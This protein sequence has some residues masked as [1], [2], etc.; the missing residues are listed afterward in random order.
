MER[1]R[2]HKHSR[3]LIISFILLAGITMVWLNGCKRQT[4]GLTSTEYYNSL[5]VLGKNASSGL[6]NLARPV[7]ANILVDS[8]RIDSIKKIHYKNGLALLISGELPNSC[9]N[10]F[11]AKTRIQDDTLFIGISTWQRK[12]ASCKPQPVPFTYVNRD[13]PPAEFEAVKIYKAG[14]LIRDFRY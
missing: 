13:L 7:P 9:S 6:I 11:N 5:P 10:L 12:S 2:I 3:Y 1:R 14:Y 4:G 8:A